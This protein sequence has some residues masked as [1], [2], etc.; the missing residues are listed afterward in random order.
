[1][2]SSAVTEDKISMMEAVAQSVTFIGAGHTT[3]SAAISCCLHELALNQEIQDKLQEEI[4]EVSRSLGGLT[5]EKLFE[6]KYLDM[7][8]CGKFFKLIFQSLF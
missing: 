4:L 3:T 1:L 7:V 5:F 6:M 2:N 8:L